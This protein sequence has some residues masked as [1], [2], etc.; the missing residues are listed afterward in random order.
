M[1][2]SKKI[3]ETCFI[4]FLVLAL[5][6]LTENI[7]KDSNIFSV[8]YVVWAVILLVIM[9]SMYH[10]YLEASNLSLFLSFKKTRKEIYRSII[11]K[12]GLI[13]LVTIPLIFIIVIMNM[14]FRKES[15][16]FKGLFINSRLIYFIVSFFAS[17]SFGVLVASIKFKKNEVV[18]K[19]VLLVLW[20]ILIGGLMFINSI[21]VSIIIGALGIVL[22]FLSKE[23]Y[24]NKMIEI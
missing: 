23:L 7:L 10:F 8:N 3:I 17:S 13:L 4:V 5:I 24:Y 15:V 16:G 12:S 6:I 9:A 2:K 18:T 1:K 20:G 14:A 11:K 21:Y 22:F 19:Q